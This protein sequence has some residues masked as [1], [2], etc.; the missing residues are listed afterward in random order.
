MLRQNE[1]FDMEIDGKL[2]SAIELCN[3]DDAIPI[4]LVENEKMDG[5]LVR[6][7]KAER[8]NYN[9]FSVVGEKRC[10]IFDRIKLS[11]ISTI[12][13]THRK[14]A[15]E[16][17]RKISMAL[18]GASEKFL[19]LETGYFPLRRI[20]IV[21][22]DDV[23]LL[24]PDMASLISVFMDDER[25]ND[26]VSALYKRKTES[27]FTLILE[28]AELLYYAATGYL[29]YEDDDVKRNRHRYYPLEECL[30]ALGD[31]LDGKTMGF[32]NVILNAKIQ[33]QRDIMGNLHAGKA[34]YW[35]NEKSKDLVWNLP[36]RADIKEREVI[37][38]SARYTS[39]KEKTVSVARRV[40]FW[41]RR[42]TVITACTIIA[43][44]AIWGLTSWIMNIME[45]PLTKDMDQEE[46]IEFVFDA[47]NDLNSNIMSTACKGTTLPQEHAVTHLFVTTRMRQSYEMFNPI[48]R[49]DKWVESGM[50]PIKESQA[51]YGTFDHEMER[52]DEDTIVV[53]Y[54]M[55]TPTSYEEGSEPEIEDYSSSAYAFFYSVTQSFDFAWNNRGWWNIVDSEITDITYDG[56]TPV[57][58]I[59]QA[60]KGIF[61][62][63]ETSG[64]D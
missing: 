23:L 24:P 40:N 4:H 57:E 55:I 6:G 49:A 62:E 16:I 18:E 30:D 32:I 1:I 42:G 45:P 64:N 26:D 2:M 61:A 53:T 37:T 34:L 33:Q 12:F 5:I 29:P 25:R 28:M 51:I 10:F 7:D 31:E 13:T 59:P 11:P 39:W 9:S 60:P 44:F 14:N 38:S 20:Y 56:Y 36:D 17:I 22:E 58:V 21:D 27:G 48:V 8:W 3:K 41:R 52:I 15:L 19:D 54:R 47:Q 63:T 50:V 43:A 46:I 35:F